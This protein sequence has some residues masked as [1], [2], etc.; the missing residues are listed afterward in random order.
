MIRSNLVMNIVEMMFAE[1]CFKQE[2]IEKFINL[3]TN[4]DNPNDPNF[5][6]NCLTSAGLAPSDLT[7][8]E[9]AEVEARINNHF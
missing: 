1:N 7:P 4:S 9:W 8:A 3:M 6:I 2:K 5:Q